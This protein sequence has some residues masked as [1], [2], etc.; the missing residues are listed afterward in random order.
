MSSIWQK[1]CLLW[2]HRLLNF[3]EEVKIVTIFGMRK[4][5]FILL[6]PIILSFHICFTGNWKGSVPIP[7]QSLE[8]RELQLSSED[9]ELFLN[10]LRKIFRWLPEERPTAE[11]LANDEFLMQDML[12]ERV[13]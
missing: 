1:W 4:V 7:E 6:H 13:R 12:T 9:K 2:D 5:C 11:E 10:F 3:F 8:T